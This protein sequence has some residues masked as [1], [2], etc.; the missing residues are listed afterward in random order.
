MSDML[1]AKE[2]QSI[3]QVDRSTVYRMAED[4]RLPAV[5]VGKQWRF[6]ARQIQRQFE[7]PPAPAAVPSSPTPAAAPDAGNLAELLPLEC[8]QLIQNSFADLLGVM[9]VITDMNG[10]PITRPSHTCGL[11]DVISQIP[12]EVQKCIKSWH[13]LAHTIEL[14]PAFSPSHLGLMCSR[15]MIR[16]GGELCG[17]VVAGCAAPEAWPPTGKELEAMAAEIG[18]AP[19]QLAPHLDDV[20]YLDQARQRQVLVTL[21]RLA[22]IV[23]HVVNER[24][25]LLGRL[26]QI[27]DL[28]KA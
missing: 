4:G 6:P 2:V 8:V 23:A 27:A 5:K 7:L 22:A 9:L 24:Q 3:L 12:N 25:S 18:V 14:E 19:A 17:M 13:K 28:A 21:Q 15:A 10:N 1:T 16:V 11:F 20:F 26:E